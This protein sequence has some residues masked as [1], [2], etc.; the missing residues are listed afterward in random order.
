M[1]ILHTQGG[2]SYSIY[3]IEENKIITLVSKEFENPL[4]VENEI[5]SFILDEELNKI[6]FEKINIIEATRNVTI[7]PNSIFNP[8]S[9]EL[10]YKLNF[11]KSD[12]D[13]I[14]YSQLNKTD[15]T[16]VFSINAK[17]K[18]VFDDIFSKYE[19]LPQSASFIEKNFIKTKISE[20]P[21]KQRMFVQVFEN[22]FEILVISEGKILAY[23]T[24]QYKSPNDILYFIINA[25]EQ[26]N[27]SQDKAEIIISGFIES[28]NLAIIHLRKFVK[29]VY[30]ESQDN[31]YKYF[32]KFQ[33]IAPH[34]FANFLNIY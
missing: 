2:L 14:C 21:L 29:T 6:N 8:N 3:D 20:Y 17:T 28:D 4:K 10:L 22:F 27:L 9:L 15:I 16:V 30:F 7:V 26:L 11:E 34:Y 18:A 13:V 31:D 5:R 33:E 19:L 25:F 24:F 1:S 12:S 23:N 32:Y